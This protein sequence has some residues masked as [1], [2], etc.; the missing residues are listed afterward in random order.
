MKLDVSF[1]KL[2]LNLYD[3]MR[4]NGISLVYLG[5]FNHQIT[6]MFTNMQEEELTRKEEERKI[7]RRVYH[8]MVETL[9]NMNK[10]SDELLEPGQVGSGFFVIG[11]KNDTYYIITSNKISNSKIDGLKAALK[12]V[13]EATPQELK[14]M[15][16]KQIKEGSLSDK[17][18][19]GLGL[20]DIARKSGYP[21]DFQFLPMD[22][23]NSFFILKVEIHAKKADVD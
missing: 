14:E 12:E 2:V 22:E 21:L 19:A 23:R 6:K 1:I 16:K 4:V 10:H 9:Q 15:F 8:A 3:E 20:I 7:V 13:N 5:E 11:K 18:G 17:G